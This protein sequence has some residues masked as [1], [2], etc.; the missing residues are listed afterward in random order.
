MIDGGTQ[1][2]DGR[3]EMVDALRGYAL[4]GLFLV[5]MIEYYE[6]YWLDPRP[7]AVH[8]WLFALFAARPMPC[9]RSASGSASTSSCTAPANGV[10]ISRA[11]SCGGW[12][13]LP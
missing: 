6:L 2:R 13:C 1:A 11:G 7:S 8:D 3:L 12:P 10:W 5:H 4:L 9:S